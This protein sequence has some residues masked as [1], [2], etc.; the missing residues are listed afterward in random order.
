MSAKRVEK[1][2]SNDQDDGEKTPEIAPPES[3]SP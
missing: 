1:L 2:E 3:K